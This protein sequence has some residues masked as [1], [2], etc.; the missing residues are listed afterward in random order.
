[1]KVENVREV[2]DN[3]IKKLMFNEYKAKNSEELIEMVVIFTLDELNIE[4]EE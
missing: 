1:M 3:V 2:I 4:Y